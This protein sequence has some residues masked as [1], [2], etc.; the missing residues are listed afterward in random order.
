MILLEK[1]HGS[2]ILGGAIPNGTR[3]DPRPWCTCPRGLDPP[4]RDD[5]NKLAPF[6]GVAHLQLTGPKA[7]NSGTAVGGVDELFGSA[8]RSGVC[9]NY[10]FKRSARS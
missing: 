5:L 6:L 8:D 1:L 7:E 2:I 9:V 4:H 3:A 10:V